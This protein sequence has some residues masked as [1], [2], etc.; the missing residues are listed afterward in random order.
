[1]VST[2]Q[3]PKTFDNFT[4][5]VPFFH[6]QGQGTFCFPINLA[7]VPSA[8]DGSNVTI[9]IVFDGGDGKLYQVQ[10]TILVMVTETDAL[11]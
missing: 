1:L 7:S 4:Q 11:C 6:Q 2:L 3:D 8:K 5:A 9:Q 10:H